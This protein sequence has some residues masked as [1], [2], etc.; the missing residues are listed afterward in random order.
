MKEQEELDKLIEAT[1]SLPAGT[2]KFL[3]NYKKESLYM[4]YDTKRIL[5][6]TFISKKD[7]QILNKY[8]MRTKEVEN[9][10]ANYIRTFNSENLN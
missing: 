6:K 5:K 1:N 3:Q 10:L 8:S 4:L 7:R 2:D 9:E